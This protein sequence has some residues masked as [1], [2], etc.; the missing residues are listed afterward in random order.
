MRGAIIDGRRVRLLDLGL[1]YE[2]VVVDDLGEER[3]GDGSGVEDFQALDVWPAAGTGD[4]GR[5]GGTLCRAGAVAPVLGAACVLGLVAARNDPH[6]FRV[7]PQQA[8][9]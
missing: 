2:S 3:L 4:Y 9:D 7:E 1:P 8:G 5:A 6:T